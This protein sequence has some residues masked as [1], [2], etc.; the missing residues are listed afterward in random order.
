M[1]YEWIKRNEIRRREE[2]NQ[3]NC[4]TFPFCVCLGRESFSGSTSYATIFGCRLFG[5]CITV[6]LENS[7][8]R[9]GKKDGW[10]EHRRWR[11]M[12]CMFCLFSIL[13]YFFHLDTMVPIHP[14]E[15]IVRLA[16]SPWAVVKD[17]WKGKEQLGFRKKKWKT[18]SF[19]MS[20]CVVLEKKAENVFTFHAVWFPRDCLG[21]KNCLNW[22]NY[23]VN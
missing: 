4:S 13:F 12:C 21:P 11:T 16:S 9:R 14:I 3:K 20:H 8:L 10:G 5:Y 18:E 23:F 2:S 1:L 17:K 19:N 22:L 6:Q 15:F 7:G